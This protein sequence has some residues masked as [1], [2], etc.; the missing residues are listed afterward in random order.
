MSNNKDL[1][2]SGYTILAVYTTKQLL[3]PL[4][5]NESGGQER[6]SISWDWRWLESRVIE[7]RLVF[8]IDAPNRRSRISADCIGRF[9]QVEDSPSVDLDEFVS[10]Q[11]VAMLLPYI[12][13]YL[14]ALT[15]NTLVGPYILP[16]LNVTEI[17]KDFNFEAA[18]GKGQDPAR[19][20][21]RAARAGR[22][23]IAASKKR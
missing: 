7:V 22:A 15:I 6:V 9:H 20:K 13:Q 16:S 23:R 3:E 11:A 4:G 12:R 5:P 8:E 18:T 21:G 17:R 2:V 1:P 10:L 19:L 14:S